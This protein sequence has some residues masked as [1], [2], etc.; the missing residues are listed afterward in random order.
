[1]TTR[2]TTSKLLLVAGGR[3]SAEGGPAVPLRRYRL[4][5]I[6]AGGQAEAG[7]AHKQRRA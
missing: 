6:V 2:P 5:R 4:A 7:K 3:G 1:M